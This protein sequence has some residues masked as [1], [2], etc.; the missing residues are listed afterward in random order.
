MIQLT[1]NDFKGM[2]P[3]CKR[4]AVWLEV[5]L[6]LLAKYE[7]NTPQRI[8]MFVAQVGHESGSFNSTIEN[9]NYSSAQLLKVF[10]RYFTKTTAKQYERNPEAIA[11]I[12]YDDRNPARKNKLGNTRDGDGWKFRGHGL[13]QLTG[14]SAITEF[15]A[16][17]D[18]SVDQ[19][20]EYLKTDRGAF[21]SA[22]WYWSRRNL[23]ARADR[24]DIEGATKI[25]N[26]GDNGLADRVSR[27]R[28]ALPIAVAAA[29]RSKQV[30]IPLQPTRPTTQAALPEVRRGSPSMYVVPVQR[31]L[32]LS[33][34]GIFGVQTEM[35]VRSW[36][37]MNKYPVTGVLT[38]EQHKKLLGV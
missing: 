7:I 2:L 28:A 35:A 33:A 17:F 36:Q 11:N 5:A 12:V 15:A 13:I 1:L 31:A 26:G 24:G 27:Y 14:R 38:P 29:E 6:P 34:D 4:P 21:E 20:L 22:C 30:T 32:K 10:G 18:M 3:G 16:A 19:A 25:I 37:R 23:N 9:L 8:A